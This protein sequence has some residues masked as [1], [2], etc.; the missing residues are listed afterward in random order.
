MPAERRGPG[1]AEK[2]DPK[3][4]DV[5]VMLAEH[6]GQVV[7]RDDLLAR[8]WPDVVVTDEVLS[9]C[10]YELRRQLSQAAGDEQLEGRDR[11]AAEARLPAEGRGHADCA[12]G[13][14][15]APSGRRRFAWSLPRLSRSSPPSSRRLWMLAIAESPRARSR[16]DPLHRRVAVRRHERGQG[17]G[18]PRGRHFRGDPQS[19]RPGRQASGHR[20]HLVVC[21]PRPALDVADIAKRLNVTHV[22]EGSVRKSGDQIRITAQLIAASDSSHV[23]SETYDREM[24]RR[25]RDPGRDRRRGATALETTLLRKF[26]GIPIALRTSRPMR[27]SCKASSS[28]TAALQATSSDRSST[29]R[30]RLRSIPRYRQGLGIA[31]ERIFDARLGRLIR[32]PSL[33][34]P[35]RSRRPGGPSSSIQISRWPT[36]AWRDFSGATGSTR[37]AEEHFDEQDTRPGRPIRPAACNRGSG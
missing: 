2:L 26:C 29:L 6:A 28:I 25:V 37:R 1:G 16:H 8:I 23:W 33:F 27:N 22:L 4:M 15:A 34:S 32:L 24:R 36:S 30:R 12:R 35:S 5:L 19:P 11:D 3:V 31:R 9:R 21:A 13:S 20:A 14:R 7:S 10:I 18:L 17:P